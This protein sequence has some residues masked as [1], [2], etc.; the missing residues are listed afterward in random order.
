MENEEI[1]IETPAVPTSTKVLTV[2]ADTLVLA[3]AV[4]VVKKIVVFGLKTL[5][6][7]TV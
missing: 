3:Q 5:R 7:R 4:F 2:A 1:I 6:N